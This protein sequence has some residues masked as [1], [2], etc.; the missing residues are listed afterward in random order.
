MRLKAI[1]IAALMVC[2]VST[3][4]AQIEKGLRYGVIAGLNCSNT[5]GEGSKSKIGFHVGARAEYNFSE[6]LYATASLLYSHKGFK[7]D[8]YDDFKAN[9]GYLELPI[10]AGYRWSLNNGLSIFG[11]TG[12]YFAY[13]I[14]GKV[15]GDG[16]ED[17]DFFGDEEDSFGAKRFDAGWGIHAGVEYSKFQIRVGYELGFTKLYDVDDSAKNRN[18]MVSVGYTF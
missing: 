6:S 9:A 12:P 5:D 18:L 11:E 1:L 16:D 3:V 10:M 15:K 14:C 4:S 7:I 2:G 8:N 17:Y 13:G